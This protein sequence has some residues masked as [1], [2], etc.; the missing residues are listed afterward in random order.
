[1]GKYQVP[2]GIRPHWECFNGQLQSY[3]TTFYVEAYTFYIFT[4]DYSLF[5]WSY[6]TTQNSHEF[7]VAYESNGFLLWLKSEVQGDYH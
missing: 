5:S 7:Y 2:L 6:G 4:M 3:H 1:M